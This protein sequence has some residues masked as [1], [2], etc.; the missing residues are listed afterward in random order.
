MAAGRK[1][2]DEL[3]ARRCLLA[4]TRAAQTPG[5]WAR[6]H[7]IDG[8]SLTPGRSTSRKAGP[9]LPGLVARRSRVPSRTPSSNSSH[10][11]RPWRGRALDM[12]WRSTVRGSSS[13]TTHPR[14]PC[15]AS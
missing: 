5:E 11:A 6:G 2:D 9:P 4:A 3:E 8:R 1:I 15:A 14:R 7:G 13:V 10:A 12:S